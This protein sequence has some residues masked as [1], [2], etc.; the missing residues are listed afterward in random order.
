VLLLLLHPAGR[1]QIRV[2]V[3]ATD[4]SG[5]SA[6]VQFGFEGAASRCIDPD[7]GEFELP[8]GGCTDPFICISFRDVR[9][10]ASACLGEGLLVDLRPFGSASDTFALG[11]GSPGS[12]VLLRW[13]IGPG[14]HFDSLRLM[15]RFGGSVVLCDMLGTDSLA[16]DPAV[17]AELLIVAWA[18]AYV[19]GAGGSGASLPAGER[20]LANYPN[21]FNP[22]TTVWYRVDA[23]SRVRLAVFDLLGREVAR[24]VDRIEEPG[25]HAVVW[26]GADQPSGWYACRLTA[27][28]STGTL[29][30][31]LLR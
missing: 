18:P 7:L 20:L 26:D 11:V 9:N 13:T 1:S 15:D 27:G 4:T 23:R 2:P 19:T 3:F 28:A 30:M 24:L 10:D 31:L 8:P 6:A 25:D 22:S 29:T 5:H 21:P 12:P 16:F 14:A 17:A